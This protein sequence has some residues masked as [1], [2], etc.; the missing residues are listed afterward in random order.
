MTINPQR[1]VAMLVGVTMD[2][3]Y[4]RGPG[5]QITYTAEAKETTAKDYIIPV[6]PT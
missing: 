5:R 1:M 6:C 2:G 3:V 4:T